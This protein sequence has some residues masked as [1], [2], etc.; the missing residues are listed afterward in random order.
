MTKVI[1]FGKMCGISLMKI[2]FY[3]LFFPE[4]DCIEPESKMYRVENLEEINKPM[5]RVKLL[6]MVGDK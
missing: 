1:V 3:N 2:G 4:A 5:Q 6:D